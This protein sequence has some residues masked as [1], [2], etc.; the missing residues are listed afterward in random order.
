MNKKA[1]ERIISIW[2]FLVWIIVLAGIVGIIW[3]FYSAEVNVR[4]IEA[5]ILSGRIVDCISENGYLVENFDDNFD[6]FSECNINK[7]IIENK[8]NYHIS[9]GVYSLDDKKLYEVIAGA[10]G[11]GA[12]CGVGEGKNMPKC[13]D[14]NFFLLNGNNEKVNVKFSVLFTYHWYRTCGYN[15]NNHN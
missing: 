3:M 9:I 10:R 1:G 2:M 11:L 5:E 4:G 12:W 15:I 6:I 8:E 7:D 14:K 13:S